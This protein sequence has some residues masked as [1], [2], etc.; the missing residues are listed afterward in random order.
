MK[1][2][3]RKAE[4]IVVVTQGIMNALKDMG[5]DEKKIHLITN[6][7]DPEIFHHEKKNKSREIYRE[8]GCKN[9]FIVIYT[10]VIGII[11][12]AWIIAE[13]AKLLKDHR[14]VDFVII[15]DGVKKDEIEDMKRKYR[16][17]N[18][19]VLGNMQPE[20]LLPYLQGADL[21]LATLQDKLFCEGTI[22]VKIFSYMACGLPVIFA[23]RGEGRT[24][25]QEHCAGVCIEPEDAKA[26]ADTV[27]ALKDAPE[28]CRRMG[29]RGMLAVKKRFSRRML[30]KDLIDVIS[31]SIE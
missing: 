27:L 8:L 21:G 26:L 10:G 6:G 23:G 1:F 24:I 2:S 9:N 30:T 11:H 13:A 31:R 20:S 3:Y 19:H 17:M 15:G 16:L 5:I 22:P 12:G 25:V 18:L 4:Q 28:E 7:V 14:G 29:E